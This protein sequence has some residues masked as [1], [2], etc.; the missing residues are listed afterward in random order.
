MGRPARLG[1]VLFIGLASLVLVLSFWMNSPPGDSRGGLVEIPPGASA[2]V[3]ALQLRAAG[4]VRSA[5][6]LEFLARSTRADQKLKAGIYRIT[7]HQRADRILQALLLGRGATVRVTIPEGFAVRQ[8]AERLG[9]HRI[10]RADEFLEEAT[11]WE[12][13]LFPDTYFFDPGSPPSEPVRV[14]RERFNVEWRNVFRSALVAG[15]VRLLNGTSDPSNGLSEGR[16]LLADGRRWTVRQAVVMASLIE[17]ETSRGEERER[18]SAVFHNRLKKG[19]R[20][21]CDPTV[22]YALGGWK[23]P[24]YKKDLLVDSPYNTYRRHGLPPGP[25]ASPGRESLAAALAPAATDALYFVSDGA[26]GHIF[27]STYEDHQRAVRSYRRGV[28]GGKKVS[29]CVA[30]HAFCLS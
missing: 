30:E 15:S 4:H 23:N 27:S 11:P 20:L 19:M 22:Q 8:M 28:K 18:V 7:A 9:S 17:R 29:A 1:G 13:F 2:R 26:G 5:G 12:G 3:I 16:F 24:L 21:E 25:I 6:W 14:L 10:C